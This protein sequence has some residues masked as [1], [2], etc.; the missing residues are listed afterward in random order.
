MDK[1]ELRSEFWTPWEQARKYI[2]KKFKVLGIKE[3]VDSEI[4][5]QLFDVELEDGTRIEA[6]HE[7]IHAKTC[8]VR[9]PMPKGR[10]LSLAPLFQCVAL[11]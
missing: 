3:D 11:E 9:Y 8:L 5:G 2:G 1:Y 10:S 4:L 7:E 6:W